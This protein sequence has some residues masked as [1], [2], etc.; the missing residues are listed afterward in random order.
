MAYEE[1][2][3]Q[4]KGPDSSYDSN[5]WDQGS[6]LLSRVDGEFGS[7]PFVTGQ[8]QIHGLSLSAQLLSATNIGPNIPIL[9]VTQG[10][11]KHPITLSGDADPQAV[12]TGATNSYNDASTYA[13]P[14]SAVGVLFTYR[15]GTSG[16]FGGKGTASRTVILSA[17]FG[18]S[19]ISDRR[20]VLSGNELKTP[21]TNKGRSYLDFE[22]I[23][24]PKST[25]ISTTISAGF[26]AAVL[27]SDYTTVN[28]NVTSYDNNW[29]AVLP[30]APLS[31]GQIVAPYS[32]IDKEGGSYDSVG[33][34]MRRLVNMGYL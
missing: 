33:Q 11:V 13:D 20:H 1:F 26:S 8:D 21:G 23:A 27:Y 16:L 30:N 9:S 7:P 14:V 22:T 3:S 34:N 19:T 12:K 32:A 17:G 31:G 28:Y 25:I 15:H 2:T 6:Y 24:H 29:G 4:S 5:S 10:G 18:G